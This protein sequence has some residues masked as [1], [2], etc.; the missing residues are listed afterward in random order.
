[1]LQGARAVNER[2]VRPCPDTP[3]ERVRR[4]LAWVR[5]AI[6]EHRSVSVTDRRVGGGYQG[7]C[8]EERAACDAVPMPV[9]P[10]TADVT[11]LDYQYRIAQTS[12]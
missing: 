12:Q 9:D 11:A 6:S 1:M 2:A 3:N 7:R 8:P 4:G 5:Q 10:V